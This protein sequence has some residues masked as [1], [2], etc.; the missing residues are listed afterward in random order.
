LLTSDIHES[1]IGREIIK[2]F[3]WAAEKKICDSSQKITERSCRVNPG[4]TKLRRELGKSGMY[5][6]RKN[7]SHYFVQ[8]MHLGQKGHGHYNGSTLSKKNGKKMEMNVNGSGETLPVK[9]L[10]VVSSYHHKNTEK[11]ANVFAK[12][13][14]GR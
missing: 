13:L 2:T 11:I 3:F 8:V 6:N 5:S 10:E 4:D 7:N 9:S 12:V 14:D 1:S